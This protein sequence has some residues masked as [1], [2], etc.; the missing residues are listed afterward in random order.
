MM[1][2]KFYQIFN[3]VVCANGIMWYRGKESL[4]KCE[5]TNTLSGCYKMDKGF[6]YLGE[7]NQTIDGI[8][9]QRWSSQT[10]HH[11]DYTDPNTYW[12]DKIEDAGSF[13]RNPSRPATGYKR[14]PWCFTSDPAR[15]WAYC[16]RE[17]YCCKYPSNCLHT[18]LITSM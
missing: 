13:C 9:C 15:R 10:P 3:C 17:G 11:H 12:D 14:W 16:Y 4:A 18:T 6:D 7:A 2:C 8:P 5:H 1:W